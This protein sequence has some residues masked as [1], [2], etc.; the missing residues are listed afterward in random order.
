MLIKYK[1]RIKCIEL[2][3][4]KK[5]RETLFQTQKQEART[6]RVRFAR[7]MEATFLYNNAKRLR[8]K[9]FY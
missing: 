8:Q 6:T 2:K 7:D 5:V 3:G 1:K 4:E 9:F